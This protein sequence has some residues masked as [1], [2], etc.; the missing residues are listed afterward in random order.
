MPKETKQKK[1]IEMKEATEIPEGKHEGIIKNFKESDFESEYDYIDVLIELVEYP[2]IEG[3]K[4]GFPER[5]SKKT[6][7]GI[8]LQKAGYELEIGKQYDINEISEF[9]FGKHITFTTFNKD[10]FAKVINETIQFLD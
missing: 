1:L 4:T 6:S 2:E 8:F 3:F 5:L 7:L 10:G 9:L